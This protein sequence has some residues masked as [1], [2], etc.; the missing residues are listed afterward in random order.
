MDQIRCAGDTTNKSRPNLLME[1]IVAEA[2]VA[3]LQK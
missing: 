1:G 2:I 3:S